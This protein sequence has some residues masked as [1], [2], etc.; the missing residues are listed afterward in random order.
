ML[1]LPDSIAFAQ[2]D[3]GQIRANPLIAEHHRII[4]KIVLRYR[5]ADAPAVLV[6]RS[7]LWRPNL[8]GMAFHAA[9]GAINIRSAFRETRTGRWIKFCSVERVCGLLLPN[10]RLGHEDQY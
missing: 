3:I 8:F 7:Q 2:A 6:I 9:F 5:K 4:A 10:L 1:Q